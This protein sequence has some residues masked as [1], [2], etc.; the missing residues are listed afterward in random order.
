MKRWQFLCAATALM[1]IAAGF[2]PSSPPDVL[3][4]GPA[5]SEDFEDGQ[6][7]GWE[8]EPGWQVVQD[9]SSYV[10]GGEGH[11]WARANQSFDG[12]LRQSFRVRLLQ[13]RI[14]LVVRLTDT[15]RYFIGFDTQGS[16]LNKQYFPD[17]F[18]NGLAGLRTPHSLD[19]WYQVEIVLKDSTIEFLVDGTQQWSYTDA[20]PLTGG[21]F[22]FETLDNSR[23]HVDDITVSP[24]AAQASAPPV[25]S[26]LAAPAS[27]PSPPSNVPAAAT[28]FTWVRTGGPL[29]GLGYDVR[30][31]PDNPDV[32]FVTDAWAGLFTSTDGGANWLP[33]NT[34]ISTRI[35]PTGDG[36][37]VFSVTIDPNQPDTMWV[38]TQFQRGIFKSVDGGR[39]WSK[40]DNGIVEA[41][42]ITFRGFSVQPGDSNVVYAAAEISSWAWAGSPRNGRSFDLT[43]GVVYKTTNGGQS[44]KAI[45]RGDNLARYIWI[46]PQDPAILYISTGFFDREAANSDPNDSAKARP[47]GEGILKSTDGGQTW[48]AVNNGLDNLYV[49]SLFMNPAH[50]DTLL[51]GTGNNEYARG[52]GVYLSTDGGASWTRTLPTEPYGI[53]SVEFS[54]SEPSIA[55]AGNDLAIYRSQDGGHT[56]GR[57]SGTGNWGPPGVC[58]GFPIDFQV[59]PRN[60]DRLFANEYGGGNFLSVDG[61]QTWTDASRGYTGALMRGLAADPSAPAGIYAAAR[62]GLYVSR[63]GGASWQGL[64]YEPLRGNDWTAVAVDPG[65]PLHILA[66]TGWIGVG[67]SQ[68]GGGTWKVVLRDD[69]GR[70]SFRAIAFSP[71]DPRQVYAGIGG[72]VN[73]GAWQS[74]T[75]GQGV[76]VSND[77]GASWSPRNSGLASDANV[78]SL[79]VDPANAQVVY[80]G[81]TNRGLL[82]SRDGGASWTQVAGLPASKAILS[83][84]LAPDNA[85]VM[86]AGFER[87]AVYR[88]TD[89]GQS[90]QRAAAGLSPESSVT[91]IVFDP[92]QAGRIAYLSDV[93]SGVYR[94]DDGGKTWS[95]LNQGLI[96]RAV[97]QLALSADGLHLYAGTEGS[98]VYRLDLN[99][100]PPAPAPGPVIE[101]APTT[102]VSGAGPQAGTPAA[103]PTAA[104]AEPKGRGPRFCGG[105]ILPF[106]LVGLGLM[107]RR[108]RSPTRS[109]GSGPRGHCA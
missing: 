55:Y 1:L 63:D 2:V 59:D 102:Y 72:F 80:A 28:N 62:S 75:P 53:Q 70:I 38:G 65:N 15:S 19:R 48:N 66:D 36:I 107:Q 9:G 10:L 21:S 26:T 39:S 17:E 23:V 4:Q 14:H 40:M 29:G 51:A 97:N 49:T 56:W 58:A 44:W 37:P 60:P 108:K 67:E 42:G 77:G 90:W 105:G 6:A 12:D 86:L 95:V 11:V 33:S 57:V 100:Q 71:S 69:S 8:L 31:R 85:S 7:Q 79:V 101:I 81:T 41:D 34:G 109:D 87:G 91:G 92:H 16:D 45:W 22:A 47:G 20:Q 76:Y 43:R 54:T 68:D 35:G 50:P 5:Y 24:G 93:S 73:V 18:Y 32:M 74:S 13:G 84:A 64:S 88:T 83:L 61:G 82:L 96:S 94:S 25:A 27:S 99:G 104:G 52:A 103:A 46:H 89:G 106:G 30:M 98:G 3:A 78:S